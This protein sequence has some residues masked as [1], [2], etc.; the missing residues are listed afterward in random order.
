MVQVLADPD[1]PRSLVRSLKIDIRRLDT[2][3]FWVFLYHDAPP[4]HI[5]FCRN[6]EAIVIGQTTR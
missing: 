4:C 1:W 3:H 2:L 5:K 6:Y